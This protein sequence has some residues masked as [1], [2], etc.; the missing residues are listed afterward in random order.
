MTHSNDVKFARE[1]I[2][3]TKSAQKRK[4]KRNKLIVRT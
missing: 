4:K 2:I 1:N 3:E